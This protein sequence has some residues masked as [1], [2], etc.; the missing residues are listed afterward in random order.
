MTTKGELELLMQIMQKY[1]LPMSPILEYAINEK[2][3]GDTNSEMSPMD[4]DV[5]NSSK[6]NASYAEM[7]RKLSTGVQKG[8]K[9]PHKAVLLLSILELVGKGTINDNKIDL[10]KTIARSFATTLDYYQLGPKIPSVWIPFWYM[11]SEPFWHFKASTDESILRNLLSFAG[12]PTIG[13]MRNVIKFAFVDEQ[14]F[15]LMRDV[16]G[17][18][19]LVNALIETYIR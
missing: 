8:K 11:K 10:N 12:H 9:L 7:F 14:L 15:E 4:L 13:Q 19:S 16:A 1:D 2:I 3:Q 6:T 5:S 17:R 18:S